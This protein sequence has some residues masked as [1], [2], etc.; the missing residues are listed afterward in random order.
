MAGFTSLLTPVPHNDFISDANTNCLRHRGPEAEDVWINNEST[1]AFGH[2]RLSI[3]DPGKEAAQPMQYLDRY[4]LIHNGELY[5]YVEIREQLLK[6][7]YQFRSHSDTEVI[8][9][10]YNEWGT[11]CLQHFDGM[12]AFTIW[13]EKEKKLFASPRS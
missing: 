13:D 1:I 3:I 12:F 6:K 9:A 4:C 7:R 2:L 10:A 11:A 5:N 8:V